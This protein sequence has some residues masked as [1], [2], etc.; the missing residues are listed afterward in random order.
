[1]IRIV[2]AL[3]K[4]QQRAFEASVLQVSISYGNHLVS[5]ETLVWYG[6]LNYCFIPDTIYNT[7]I[8]L[9]AFEENCYK[10]QKAK[11]QSQSQ[12]SDGLGIHIP[13]MKSIL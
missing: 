2:I 11:S 3:G 9:V 4:G 10:N 13:N 12:V 5:V 1:M 6:S 7:Q 8:N